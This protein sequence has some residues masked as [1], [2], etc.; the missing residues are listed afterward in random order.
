MVQHRIHRAYDAEKLLPL[1]EEE[2]AKA[3]F[4]PTRSREEI[5]AA[6]D[7][8]K[9]RAR[10]LKDFATVFRAYFSE[11]ST[12]IPPLLPKFLKRRSRARIPRPAIAALRGCE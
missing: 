7:L 12:T 8:L 9:P 11:A 2:W 5:L 1:I 6:I 10:N 3:G 4:T